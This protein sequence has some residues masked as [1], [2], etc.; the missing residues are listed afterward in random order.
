M[1]NYLGLIPLFFQF[2][3]PLKLIISR[4]GM[5]GFTPDNCLFNSILII[6]VYT[7]MTIYQ[8]L[9]LYELILEIKISNK[10]RDRLKFLIVSI[11]IIFFEHVK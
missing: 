4:H 3:T 11:I 8:L 9:K 5:K 6:T 10:R 1:D 2:H 7:M